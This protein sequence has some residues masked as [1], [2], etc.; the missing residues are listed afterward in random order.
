VVGNLGSPEHFDYT[1]VGDT[2]NTASRLEGLTRHFG[3]PVV[4]SE[5]VVRRCTRRFFLRPLGW[6]QVKG[7]RTPLAIYELRTAPDPHAHAWETFL[8]CLRKGDLHEARKVLA[9]LPTEPLVE[10]Y[11]RWIQQGQIRPD[12]TVTFTQ[13]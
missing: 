13:K 4:V 10:A 7:R 5:D 1:A 11:R 3:V 12:G 6:V 8:S 2:V 9:S